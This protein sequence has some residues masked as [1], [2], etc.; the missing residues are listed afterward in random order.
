M[1]TEH[2]DESR[3][4]QRWMPTEAFVSLLSAPVQLAFSAI[5]RLVCVVAVSI[6]GMPKQQRADSCYDTFLCFRPKIEAKHEPDT[7]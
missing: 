6:F 5:E 2:D 1:D 3:V 7:V 4:R